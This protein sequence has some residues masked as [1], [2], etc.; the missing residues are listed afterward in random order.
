[1]TYMLAVDLSWLALGGYLTTIL[2]YPSRT[3]MEI[4]GGRCERFVFLNSAVPGGC[5]HFFFIIINVGIRN[6]F[7]A[8]QLTWIQSFLFISE[9]EVALLIDTISAYSFSATPVDLSEKILS[10]TANITC[11]AA[12]GKSFQ[13]IKGFDGKRFEEV[14]R[15]A[16][17]ILA[18]FSAADFFPKDGWIIERLTG[19]LHSRLERSFR[20]LDV[21]YRRVIDD[22]IKLE[23]EKEDIVGGPLK[24]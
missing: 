21:L 20:E 24:L 8:T 12:F 14:I 9:E 15:E 2:M 4:I 7:H 1:M 17:A 3:A 6:N 18:S 22:H 19:L 16:S 23:E 13:E 10:F 11:R 5:S